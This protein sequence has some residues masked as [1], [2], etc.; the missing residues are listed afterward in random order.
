MM[1]ISD[2]HWRAMLRQVTRKT[3]LYTEMVVDDVVLH[4]EQRLDFFLGTHAVNEHPSVIQLGGHE[5]ES[6]ARAAEIVSRYGN[7]SEINLSTRPAL[8][9]RVHET[10]Q[11]AGVR[12]LAWRSAASGHASC[13]SR[14]WCAGS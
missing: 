3:V 11:T 9:R 8:L 12:A 7:Y 10:L 1:E 4:N 14:T 6:L 13:W 2:R 5:P